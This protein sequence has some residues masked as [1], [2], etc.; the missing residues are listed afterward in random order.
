MSENITTGG[1]G[2]NGS[3]TVLGKD[4]QPSV[5]MLSLDTESVIGAGHNGRAGRLTMYDKN[6][7]E[8]VNLTTA[9]AHL[10]VGG[11]GVSGTVSVLGSDGQPVIE[12]LGRENESVIGLGR[13]KRP[14]R[15][16]LYNGN[17]DGKNQVALELNGATGDI[18]LFNADCAEEFDLAADC[19][20]PEPGAVV[21]M[22]ENRCIRETATAYDRR[23]AGV[24]SGAGE[25]RPALVLDRRYTASTRLPVAMLGKVLCRVDASQAPVEIGDLLTT[26]ATP[27]HAMKANDMG[28]AFGSVIGKAMGRLQSGRGLIPVLVALG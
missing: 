5:Q 26:S 13:P 2:T 16:A 6:G 21:V 10:K 1:N 20:P 19:A 24:V 12:L 17:E 28:R 8:T 23:V 11:N 7:H 25:Y 27:G 3:V 22:D 4:G 15:I 18:T 9:D 14:A